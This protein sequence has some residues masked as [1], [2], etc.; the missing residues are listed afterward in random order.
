MI[1]K[2][3]SNYITISAIGL[4]LVSGIIVGLFLG[5]LFDNWF[6]KEYLFKIIFL[7]L[8]IMAGFYN[9]YKDAVKY[10]KEEENKSNGNT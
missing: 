6:H 1:N 10:I 5:Y 4:H 8:G 2:K 9:M 7:I 3:I